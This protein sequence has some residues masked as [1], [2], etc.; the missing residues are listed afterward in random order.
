[1]N[2]SEKKTGVT[3]IISDKMDF[4]T[5]CNKRQRTHNDKEVNPTRR[6]NIY[7]IYAPNIGAPKNIKQILSHLRG[8][9]TAIQ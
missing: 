5:D 9:S 8:R 6:Y 7:N 3:I 2:G 1:M 4:K